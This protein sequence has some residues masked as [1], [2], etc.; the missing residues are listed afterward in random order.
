M[1][2]FPHYV[3]GTAPDWTALIARFD[4]LDEMRH[5]PQ[6]PEWHGEGDVLTHTKMVAEAL[7]ALPEYQALDGQTQHILFA[8]AL[9]HDVEKR[10]TTVREI[11]DGR[12][13]IVSPR[14][15]KKGEKTARR[16]LYTEL[17]AP[18]AVREQ[19][20]KL[21]RWHG[22]PLWA[23]EKS[24]PDKAVIAV[25]QMLD[26]RLLAMLAK[27]D[28][29]GRICADQDDL[30][31]RIELFETLCRDNGCWG[32]A[33]AF[34]SDYGRFWYLSRDNVLPDYQPFDDAQTDVYLLSALPGSG[35]DT[36]IRQHF[37]D[38]PVL[39]IDDIRRANGL[40]PDDKKD[41]GRAVQLAKEQAKQYL[42]QQ[43][44]FVF[45]ATNTTRE[46]RGKWLQLFHDY[47]ARTHLLYLEVPYPQ[48]L[49]QNRN[50]RHAVPD[51]VLHRLL[52]KLDI[53]E[54]GEAHT[55]TFIVYS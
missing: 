30:L 46:M 23:H 55:L 40:N 17:N 48:L 5:V 20:A 53:P 38:L 22:L 50:R 21:V 24:N 34:A 32:E 11:I 2:T 4:W 26:T 27:A 47:H 28:V 7:I 52:D 10:S 37:A 8:A 43:Q 36:Y 19:I 51:N 15:A 25:S 33:R 13:R 44:S 39:S 42:R 9:L 6:D 31:L 45:N 18:F 12:E 29:L 35:K 16:L 49:T 41:N 1:W 54:Y 14:H 3:Q